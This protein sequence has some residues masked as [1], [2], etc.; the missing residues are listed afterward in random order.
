MGADVESK[1]EGSSGRKEE[2][3]KY[4]GRSLGKVNLEPEPPWSHSHH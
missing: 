3:G 4:M 2:S 1:D